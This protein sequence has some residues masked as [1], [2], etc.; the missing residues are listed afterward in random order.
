MSR[1]IYHLKDYLPTCFH[2]IQIFRARFLNF[3]EI[4]SM[5]RILGFLVIFLPSVLSAQGVYRFQRADSVRVLE[6]S[7]PLE[8]AW[9]GGLN[10]VL[11][12]EIDLNFDGI[13]DL[14][15]F[16]KSGNK[17]MPFL[18]SGET[19]GLIYHFAPQYRK[20]FPFMK[21]WFVLRDYDSD[22]KADIFTYFSGGTKIYRN[23]GNLSTGL[24]FTEVVSLLNSD[25]DGLITSIF[26]PSTDVPG[27]ADLDN[28]G[29]LDFLSFDV[30]G[31]C[32]DYHKNLS[33]ELFGHAD[34]L[35]F[36]LVTRNWGNFA[37]DGFTN[38]ISLN[39]DCGRNLRHA[40][41]TILLMDVNG[42]R[43]KD[44][45][46]GDINYNNLV[47]LINGGTS[48]NAQMV[49]SQLNFPANFGP[50]AAVN[51]TIFP[52]AS[53]FD[54]NNDGVK[55]LIVSPTGDGRSENHTGIWYYKNNGFDSLPSFQL[56]EQGFLQRSMIDLG[57]G[58]YPAFFDFDADGLKD[59][60]IGNYGY[61]VSSANYNGRLRAYRNTGTATEPEYTFH[62]ADFANLSSANLDGIYPS[63]GDLDGDGDMDLLVGEANGRLH[64]YRNTAAAGQP[65]VYTLEAANYAGI[66]EPQ[67]SAPCLFDLNEDGKLDLLVGSRSGRLNYYQNQGSV[68][69]PVFSATPTITNVGGV[70]TVDQTF[71]FFGFST[72]FVF[73]EAN[74]FQL[75]CGSYSGRIFH[76]KGLRGNLNGFWPLV[77]DKTD[78]LIYEGYRTAVSVADINDDGKNDMILGNYSGGVSLFYGL[79]VNT[80]IGEESAQA[81][82]VE[83]FPNPAMDWLQIRMPKSELDS[84]KFTI[85][86]LNGRTL[87]IHSFSANE[88]AVVDI[89]ALPAG[90]YLAILEADG[91]KSLTR[92]IIK[93]KP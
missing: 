51:T 38:A 58:A 7:G 80:S 6:V 48:A 44:I 77:S 21:E 11:A 12:G 19:S 25:Y 14:V 3:D 31:G 15:F 23:T 66:Q 85:K 91:F 39:T 74:D 53:Y 33:V 13:N 5:N 17:L 90:M 87:I 22:G 34:S 46:L 36:E 83:L 26:V 62:S 49:Q 1:Q 70:N 42:D 56:I 24:Q 16:D 63:F 84:Y 88:T 10:F 93:S 78:S 30:F 29:D 50:T 20:M 27:I 37:E 79:L 86:D 60:V 45:L 52:A 18:N 55:D 73:Q 9:A 8:N 32:V 75:F 92:K 28:D 59:L 54:L 68:N 40:G 81:F 76:Y 47:L 35:K 43:K 57:E 65:A 67:F 4:F 69:V 71:S 2:N 61:F 64:Y 89:S 41:S 82:D 72:P